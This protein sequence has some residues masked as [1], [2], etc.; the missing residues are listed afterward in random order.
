M[1]EGVNDETRLVS[2]SE[3]HV[4]D[5]RLP[6]AAAAPV[7]DGS[8]RRSGSPHSLRFLAVTAALVGIAIGA[9]GVAIAI[10]VSDKSPG[11]QAK[12]SS[13]SPPDAGVA[14]ERDI[15]N[16]VAPLYRATSASHG[17]ALACS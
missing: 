16:A 17:K 10:L 7:G 15:A 12:W 8:K 1:A 4:A 6:A 5:A 11:P 9:I 14:G 3:D 13:F 2:A